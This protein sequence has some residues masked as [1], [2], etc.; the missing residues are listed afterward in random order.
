LSIEDKFLKGRFTQIEIK[1]AIWSYDNTK[2]NMDLFSFY[3]KNLENNERGYYSMDGKVSYEWKFQKNIVLCH[4][5]H[6]Y[7]RGIIYQS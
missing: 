5:S 2:R 3:K 4:L 7:L 6:L 1:K